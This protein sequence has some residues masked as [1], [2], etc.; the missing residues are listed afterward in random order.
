MGCLTLIILALVGVVSFFS[1]INDSKPLEHGLELASKNAKVIE[2]LGEPIE[3][4]G[5]PKGEM[6]F[7]SNSGGQMNMTFTIEGPKGSA[8]LVIEAIEMND[9]WIYEQLSVISETENVTI[10]LLE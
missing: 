4:T 6:T 8:L 9:E 5:I 2:L 1:F 3:K 7:D 10:D